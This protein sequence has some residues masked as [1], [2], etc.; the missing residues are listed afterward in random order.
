MYHLNELAGSAR[1]A[2]AAGEPPAVDSGRVPGTDHPGTLTSRDNLATARR[3]VSGPDWIVPCA[4][5]DA[6]DERVG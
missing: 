1:Q 5:R 3:A 4:A 6:C 2:I